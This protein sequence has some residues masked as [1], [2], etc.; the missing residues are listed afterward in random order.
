LLR[1]LSRADPQ[2]ATGDPE[3]LIEMSELGLRCRVADLYRGSSLDP[4]RL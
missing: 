4:Q 2:L 3:M 1:S